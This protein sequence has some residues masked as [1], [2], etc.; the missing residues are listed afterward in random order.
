MWIGFMITKINLSIGII[1]VLIYISA[2][3]VVLISVILVLGGDLFINRFYDVALVISLPYLFISS[4][5]PSM[6]LMPFPLS[7]SS[8][9]MNS[10]ATDL[11]VNEAWLTVLLSVYFFSVGLFIT[12]SFYK[13]LYSKTSSGIRG[14][15]LNGSSSTIFL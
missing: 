4:L 2:I 1:F 11:L 9:G 7:T 14:L 13:S 8:I 10:L 6:L 5:Q 15:T 12:G 3:A